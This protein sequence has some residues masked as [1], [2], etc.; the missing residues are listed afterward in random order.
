M[1]ERIMHIAMLLYVHK[2]I[3]AREA[4]ERAKS[5]VDVESEL[6]SASCSQNFRIE[7]A[8]RALLEALSY[9]QFESVTAEAVALKQAVDG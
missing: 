7:K 9:E 5:F 1:N 3:T 4:F 2:T 8:A 6:F